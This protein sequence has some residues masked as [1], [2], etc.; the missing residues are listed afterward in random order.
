MFFGAEFTNIKFPDGI[1]AEELASLSGAT[2]PPPAVET[3]APADDTTA[4]PNNNN[5]PLVIGGDETD[6]SVAV[7]DA[8]NSNLGLIIGIAAG[9]LVIFGV[10][11]TIIVIMAKKIKQK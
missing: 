11:I 9:V 8:G 6:A 10:L 5:G 4:A 1:T 3:D 2:T 7:G